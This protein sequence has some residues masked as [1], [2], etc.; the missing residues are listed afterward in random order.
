MR[1]LARRAEH[2]VLF[3]AAAAVVSG[4]GAVYAKL[5]M[6]FVSFDKIAAE[7]PPNAYVT[8]A[9][10]YEQTVPKEDTYLSQS[11]RFV[12][13]D[14]VPTPPPPARRTSVTQK[15]VGRVSRALKARRFASR[16]SYEH[17]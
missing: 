16:L 1:C 6:N 12:H 11:V 8:R 9:R 7:S 15:H 3:Y 5:A 4:G 17:S 14:P 10:C 2:F 13:L